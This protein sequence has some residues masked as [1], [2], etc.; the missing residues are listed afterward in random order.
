MIYDCFPFFNELDLL[1]I[2]LAELY[3]TVDK[4]VLVEATKTF[5]KQPKN[6]IYKEN[7][8]RFSPFKDKIIHIVLDD[9]PGFFSKFR[10]PRPWDISHHQKNA[11]ARGLVNCKADDIILISDLDEIPR[12]ESILAFKDRPGIKVF[13][14]RQFNYFLNCIAVRGPDEVH[15][16]QRGNILFWKGVVMLNYREFRSFRSTRRYHDESEPEVC[17]IQEGGWHFSYLGG[18]EKV[19]YKMR[20]LEH[21]NEKHYYYDPEKDMEKLKR[22]IELGEDLFDREYRYKFIEVDDTYP[23]YLRKNIG[24]YGHLLKR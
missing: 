17:C 24:K 18:Y 20:S 9:Y 3:D 7:Q 23:A 2:R 10:V 22:K 1:E 5:Q 16:V 12:A 13:E 14:Q 8:E 19:M 11:V 21:A 6:L 4:F 15:L